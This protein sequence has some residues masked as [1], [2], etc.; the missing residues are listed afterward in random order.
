MSW[1]DNYRRAHE[2]DPPPADPLSRPG[3]APIL[4]AAL[5]LWLGLIVAVIGSIWLADHLI[6][7]APKS[8]PMEVSQ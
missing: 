3:I 7:P 2:S 5:G 1:P 8:C 4:V 6:A